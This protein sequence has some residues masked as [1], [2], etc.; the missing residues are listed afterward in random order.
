MIYQDNVNIK[1]L[2]S[3]N[4]ATVNLYA[5]WEEASETEAIITVKVENGTIDKVTQTVNYNESATFTLTPNKGHGTPSVTCTN[6]QTGTIENNILKIDNVTANTTCDVTFKAN[7]Y[8]VKYNANNGTGTMENSSH[9]YGIS[10]ELSENKFTRNGYT[11]SGW[12]TEPNGEVAY[13]DKEN[14]RDLTEENNKVINLYA[15]WKIENYTIKYNLDGGEV[16]N[17]ESY[18]IETNTFKLN[19]PVKEGYVF[20]GWTGSNGSAKEKDVTINKGTIGNK[21]YTANYEEAKYKITYK[22]DENG[23]ITGITNEE[24]TY[25]NNPNGTTSKPN[26]G[27]QVL[28]WAIDKDVTL[29]DGTKILKG[30]PVTEEQIKNILVTENL[31]ITIYHYKIKYSITYESSEN[32]TIS[33]ITNEEVSHGNS[34]L[35]TKTNPNKGY[36]LAHYVADKDVT[37]TTGE[38][39]KANSPINED[40]LSKI[41]VKENL[42]ITAIYEIATYKVTYKTDGNGTITGIKEETKKY[43]ENPSGTTTIPNK[44]YELL[45]WAANKEVILKD[46]TKIA[47]GDVI[48]EEEI[49][50]IILESDLILTAHHIKTTFTVYYKNDKGTNI[51]G[52]LKEELKEGEALKGTT[53]KTDN[54]NSSVIF[55]GNKDVTLKDGTIIKQGNIIKPQEITNIIVKEDLILTAYELKN[56]SANVNVPDTGSNKSLLIIATGITLISLGGYV[57]YKR[58]KLD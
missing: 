10:K 5:I 28:K 4:G 52:I 32:G 46:G 33:G 36:V 45:K 44:N 41:I 58:K 20:T 8:E 15:V 9:T 30:A 55:K 11:F 23:S 13:V 57:F 3:S 6:N 31:V 38:V 19:N 51:T 54:L 37:L 24:V 43:Q 2:A 49:K 7:T 40:D 16:T 34:P 53:V 27:Y 14:V 26:E 1:N 39:I 47:K 17:P 56:S 22:S 12:S 21:E 42:K 50:E 48:T 25:K 18:N 35:G 29:K